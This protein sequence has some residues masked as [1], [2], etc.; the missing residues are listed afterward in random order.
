M[1]LRPIQA[2]RPDRILAYLQFTLFTPHLVATLSSRAIKDC[3]AT[4]ILQL[5]ICAMS[6][7]QSD[8]IEVVLAC[9][10]HQGGPLILFVLQIHLA[11]KSDSESC[12]SLLARYLSK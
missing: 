10:H 8:N 7:Q 12:H 4:A 5:H 2:A 11:C 1:V 3:F 6:E 9:R